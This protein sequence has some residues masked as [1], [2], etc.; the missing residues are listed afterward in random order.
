MIQTRTTKLTVKIPLFFKDLFERETDSTWVCGSSGRS[1]GRESPSRFPLNTENYMGLDPTTHELMTWAKTKS[2][3]TELTEP[4]RCP[5]KDAY[6]GHT[7]PV[8]SCPA[9]HITE[10]WKT[11]QGG[12]R[13]KGSHQASKPIEV[14]WISFNK[15]EEFSLTVSTKEPD[16]MGES[17]L[18]CG[19]SWWAETSSM[20][21]GSKDRVGRSWGGSESCRKPKG[22]VKWKKLVDLRGSLLS[23]GNS[24]PSGTGQGKRTEQLSDLCSLWIYFPFFLLS[25]NTTCE[26][27]KLREQLR[28][29]SETW[30]QL[31]ISDSAYRVQ[32]PHLLCSFFCLSRERGT[33]YCA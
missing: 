33:L 12:C 29:H 20:S 14:R 15:M 21:R 27:S 30:C 6:D 8:C 24:C 31:S 32:I 25:C 16:L 28:T 5:C 18:E 26:Q 2:Q 11:Q 13:T 17:D 22:L 23:Q 3:G 9:R 19:T 1:R 10:K 7:L 4:S